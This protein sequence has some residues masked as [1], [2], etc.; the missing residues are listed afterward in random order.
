MDQLLTAEDKGDYLKGK[1]IQYLEGQI[2]GQYA[3]HYNM[4]KGLYSAEDKRAAVEGFV[5]D[6]YKGSFQT[7]MSSY[8]KVVDLKK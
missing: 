5:P 7:A 6:S 1:G 4:A 8:D 3:G 2:P